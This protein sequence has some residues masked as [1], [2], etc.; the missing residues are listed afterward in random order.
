M[1]GDAMRSAGD[2]PAG[3]K[4]AAWC[5]ALLVIVAPG[6][7]HAYA[8]RVRRGALWLAAALP[9]QAGLLAALLHPE[10]GAREV[11]VLFVGTVVAFLVLQAVDAARCARRASPRST[12]TWKRGLLLLGGLVLSAAVVGAGALLGAQRGRVFRTES[13]SMEPTLAPGERFLVDLWAYGTGRDPERGDVV[14]YRSPGDRSRLFVHRVVGLPGDPV[15]V[16]EGRIFVG[17][18]SVGAAA[19]R[20]EPWDDPVSVPAGS[21]YVVGDDSTSKLRQPQ[22]GPRPRAA[23]GRP[24]PR[25]ARRVVDEP[26][27]HRALV[28]RRPP[29]AVTGDGRGAGR[30]IRSEAADRGTRTEP[31][32]APAPPVAEV[33]ARDEHEC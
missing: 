15:S 13:A 17:E 2:V 3:A 10:I 22:Q 26:G 21:Y 14:V 28:P 25:R 32:S 1:S 4:P 23:R 6:L 20:T 18:R 27:R 8:G 9:V 7:G 24:R 16:R 11:V 30:R 12:P 33:P 31:R 29:R 19:N 5:A